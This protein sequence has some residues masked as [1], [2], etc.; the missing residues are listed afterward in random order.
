MCCCRGP[1]PS[2]GVGI[3]PGTLM[4]IPIQPL[5]GFLKPERE[6]TAGWEGRDGLDA[7]GQWLLERQSL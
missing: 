2:L 4:L 5:P 3:S 1:D 6:T 7:D